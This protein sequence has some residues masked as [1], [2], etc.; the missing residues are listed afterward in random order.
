M[1]SGAEPGPVDDPARL[2]DA[3]S[4]INAARRDPVH[5]PARVGGLLEGFERLVATLPGGDRG[6]AGAASLAELE[7]LLS[8]EGAGDAVTELRRYL[9]PVLD[10]LMEELLDHPER[11]LAAYGSLLPGEDN[12]HHVATLVGRWVPGTVEGALI[13][14]GWTARQGYP[15]FVPRVSGAR[16]AVKVFES[17]ALPEAW[18]RL[19]AFEGA[20][21]RRI[22][23]PVET[24]SGRVVC[25]IY[26]WIGR[27][28]P[29]P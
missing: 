11:R 4:R 1:T 22:L 20:S 8:G 15:G 16:V 2:L 14:R 9:E 26:E 25:N 28:T 13:D 21:C 3:L 23:I 6:P 12:H 27:V 18:G 29:R 10:R 7:A 19:D 24:E 5:S 17:L